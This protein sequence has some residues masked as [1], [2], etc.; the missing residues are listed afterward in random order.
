MT[1]VSNTNN[2]HE[3]RNKLK[4]LLI[5][6]INLDP[7]EAADLEIGIFNSTID[8]ANSLKISL[9]WASDLFTDS[10]LNIA[11]SVYSNLNKDTYIQNKELIERFKKKEFLPHKLPYMNCEEIFPERWETIIEK[12]KL[13]F[14]AAYEIKQVSMTDAIK[15]GKCKNNKISYYELQTRSGDESM[16]IFY[17]C[18]IC[19]HKWKN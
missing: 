11:R 6:D 15:C 17:N 13:K 1:T 8:Y 3:I 19:G 10:Y 9:S 14:K 2:K 16:T 5:N 7:V 4:N 18:I 12:Q